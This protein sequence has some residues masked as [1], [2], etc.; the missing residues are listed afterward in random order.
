MSIMFGDVNFISI[1]MDKNK[2]INTFLDCR[3]LDKF[4]GLKLIVYSISG[5]NFQLKFQKK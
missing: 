4:S 5:L 1:F 3:L 2:T